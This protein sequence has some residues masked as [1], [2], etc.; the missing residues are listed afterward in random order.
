MLQITCPYCGTRD[1]DEFTFGGEAHIVRPL[2]PEALNDREWGDYLFMRENPK[3]DHKEQWCHSASCGKWFNV[4]RNTVT[5]EVKAVY[6]V[7]EQPPPADGHEQLDSQQRAT[8]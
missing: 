4:I 1:Q 7:G 6:K 2:D 3:G 8:R 5:Y